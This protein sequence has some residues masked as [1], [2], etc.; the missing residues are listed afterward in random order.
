M[1]RFL[2][3]ILCCALLTGTVFAA[4]RADEIHNTTVVYTDGSADVVLSVNITLDEVRKDLTFPLPKGVKNVQLNDRPVDTSASRDNPGVVL[5]DLGH[6][7]TQAGSYNLVFRYTIPALISYGEPVKVKD[8]VIV[9]GKEVVQEKEVRPLILDAPLLSGFEYPVDAL[10]FTVTLPQGVEG[11]PVFESGYLLQSIESDLDYTLEDGILTGTVTKPMK[12]KETL[13]MTM[14]V[15]AEHFPELVIIEEGETIHLKYMAA[16]A[17]VAL[18]FWLLFLRSLPVIPLR[19]YGV[20]AGVHAGE[21]GSWLTMDGGDLTALIFQ[22]A[23]LGYLHIVPDKR[24][25]VWLHK[26]MDMGNERSP[27]EMRIFRQLFGN[28]QMVEGTGSRYARLW[29]QVHSTV[30]NADQITTGGRGARG[31]FRGIAV[32]A[33]A[34][35]G[36]A[37][38]QN[39]IEEGTWQLV[40]MMALAILG[41]LMGWRIQSAAACLHLR[42]RDPLPVGILCAGLWIIGGIICDR[43]LGGLLSVGIQIGAG[44]FAAWGGK[45]TKNGWMTACQLMGMRHWLTGMKRQQI[46]EKLEYNPDFFFEMVPY[47]LAMGAESGFAKRFGRRIMPQC[48]YLEAGR[49]EKR[50]A[51]EWAYLMRQIAEKLDNGAK[52]IKQYRR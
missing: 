47:A 33:S 25:R 45:R 1:R 41:I 3:L 43:P 20:P 44:I 28:N 8:T 49:S 37:M 51:Q 30:D 17:V 26:R 2:I 15:D 11:S 18:L 52:R 34:L 10:S 23:Q 21:V 13:H 35:S 40:L 12:D 14:T 48:G 9:D 7:C 24:D 5:V 19:S 22:W 29:H 36:A 39:M 42:R 4:D 6:H 38:G 27:F 31:V 16:V 50:T 32:M 46:A